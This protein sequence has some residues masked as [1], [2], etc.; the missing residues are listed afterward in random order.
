MI[1]PVKLAKENG[2]WP[3][4][5]SPDDPEYRDKALAAIHKLIADYTSWATSRSIFDDPGPAPEPVEMPLP[6]PDPSESIE[7]HQEFRRVTDRWYDAE[8]LPKYLPESELWVAAKKLHEDHLQRS[9]IQSLAQHSKNLRWI[10][11]VSYFGSAL[12]AGII[13]ALIAPS[14][15]DDLPQTIIGA[16]CAVAATLT[17]FGADYAFNKIEDRMIR[18][19]VSK[20]TQQ[21]RE[22][23]AKCKAERQRMLRR[24]GI[25]DDGFDDPP[26][27]NS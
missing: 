26:A 25:K 9:R 8:Y 4:F 18:S 2:L 6:P 20:E 11:F 14:V 3:D 13:V 16:I 12:A 1:N 17:V 5:G 10:R 15:L 24:L 21:E 19:L 22:A 7:K 27:T 23:E